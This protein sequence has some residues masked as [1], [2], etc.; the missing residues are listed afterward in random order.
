MVKISRFQLIPKEKKL[1]ITEKW[2]FF[3][4]CPTPYAYLLTELLGVKRWFFYHMCQLVGTTYVANIKSVTHSWGKLLK[5]YSQ[6][7]H[8]LFCPT[9]LFLPTLFAYLQKEKLVVCKIT[10][11][12]SLNYA[13]SADSTFKCR[14]SLFF[15]SYFQKKRYDRHQN[16][17]YIY[18]WSTYVNFSYLKR[19]FSYCIWNVQ[20]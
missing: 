6:M 20:I 14:R 1:K 5:K 18:N 12:Y 16:D 9:P 8:P 10:F 17:S 11:S 3:H 13:L 4:V 15:R 7:S 19:F 2:P